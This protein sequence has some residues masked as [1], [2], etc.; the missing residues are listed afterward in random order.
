MAAVSNPVW[1]CVSAVLFFSWS[2]V[3]A[4][5]SLNLPLDTIALPPGFAIE[6]YTS[7]PVPNARTLVLS[8]DASNGTIVY[9]S[10][11]G[12]SNVR[13]LLFARTL[14]TSSSGPTEYTL[15]LQV[16]AV[17]DHDSDG[18][19]DSVVTVVS[20]LSAPLGL[21]YANNSLWVSTTPTIYRFDNVDTLARA[22]KVRLHPLHALH[23]VYTHM[24][25]SDLSRHALS[26]Y[27][28]LQPHQLDPLLRCRTSQHLMLCS[29]IWA[30]QVIMATTT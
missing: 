17:I 18:T 9:V 1:C 30:C 28:S 8:D 5:T 29:L 20:N 11:N 21:A 16:Y 26:T 22:G 27:P 15:D 23:P 3:S 12:R 6:L 19:A 7:I 2:S 14:C 13:L 4:Q 25:T 24:R 10:T